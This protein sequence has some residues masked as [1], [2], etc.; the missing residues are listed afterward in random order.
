MNLLNIVLV[1]SLL[2]VQIHLLLIQLTHNRPCSHL[3]LQQLLI[4]VINFCYILFILN[5]ELMKVDKLQI[6]PKFLLLLDH[7]V[8]FNDLSL[9]SFDLVSELFY[10]DLFLA[11]LVLTVF[12]DFFSFDFSCAGVLTVDEDLSVE[13]EGV[14]SDLLDW[15]IRLIQYSLKHY[16]S[17]TKNK[18]LSVS[19][20]VS[21]YSF[22][23]SIFL[24]SASL[25]LV[26]ISYFSSSVS[27]LLPERCLL[28]FLLSQRDSLSSCYRCSLRF[29]YDSKR[30][31]SRRICSI[32]L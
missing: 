22:P 4:L 18:T 27:V 3:Q 8:G 20:I 7:L 17:Q 6:V 24:F 1:L 32:S 13:V 15:H 11:K 12:D 25:S 21:D 29:M 31:F 19:K 30:R 10:L 26:A 5:L 16:H 9:E 2:I 14:F 23:W 28:F